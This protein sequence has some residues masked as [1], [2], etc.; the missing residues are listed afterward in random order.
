VLLGNDPS[1]TLEICRRGVVDLER[2]ADLQITCTMWAEVGECFRRTQSLPASLPFMATYLAKAA[3]HNYIANF[4]C[5]P[6]SWSAW[7]KAHLAGFAYAEDE[8]EGGKDGKSRSRF[9]VRRRKP[10]FRVIALKFT[11]SAAAIPVSFRYVS[12]CAWCIARSRS[13]A[14]ISMIRSSPSENIEPIATV[15]PH[16]L[17][18]NRDWPL[19]FKLK[20]AEREFMGKTLFVCRLEEPRSEMSVHL[21][22]RT[23]NLLGAIIKSSCL[24]VFL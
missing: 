8:Q 7:S 13:T 2:A 11:S 22:A 3:G 21:D 19:T 4:L 18:H 14:L 6:T 20:A 23:D 17:V 1:A 10:V 16:T 5:G 15:E 9:R 12:T 24:P